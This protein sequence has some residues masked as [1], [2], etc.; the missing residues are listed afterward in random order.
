MAGRGQAA[1][2]RA[3]RFR[4]RS[5]RRC[6][7]APSRRK[8]RRSRN[9]RRARDRSAGDVPRELTYSERPLRCYEA[10]PLGGEFRPRG[11][12]LR[13]AAPRRGRSA[14]SRGPRPGVRQGRSILRTRGVTRM[15]SQSR[16]SPVPSARRTSACTSR[17][18][19]PSASSALRDPA[20]ALLEQRTIKCS[21]PT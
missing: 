3:A 15:P 21:A 9:D 1:R 18:S 16:S 7:Q 19:M 8:G 12:R 2:R 10:P 20:V 4:C 6:C 5:A 14:R 13:R 17:T 11:C